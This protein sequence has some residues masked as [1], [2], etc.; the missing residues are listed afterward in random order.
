[1]YKR[2]PESR[3]ELVDFVS[4]SGN[5]AWDSDAAVSASTER[6]GELLQLIVSLREYQYA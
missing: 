6:V 5:A 1:M 4:E 3:K 2:Q